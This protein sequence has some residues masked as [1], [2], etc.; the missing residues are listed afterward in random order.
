MPEYLVHHFMLGDEGDALHLGAALGTRQWVD[1]VDSRSCLVPS[2]RWKGCTGTV[3]VGRKR[4]PK[5]DWRMLCDGG[6]GHGFS[7]G[8]GGLMLWK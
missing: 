7:T 6:L 8:G 5:E 3:F 4:E 1:L 2:A